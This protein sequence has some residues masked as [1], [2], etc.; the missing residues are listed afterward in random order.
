LRRLERARFLVERARRNVTATPVDFKQKCESE[1][2]QLLTD[3]NEVD[4]EIRAAEN[5][6]AQNLV[7]LAR[8]AHGEAERICGRATNSLPALAAFRMM[9]RMGHQFLLQAESL[10]EDGSAA[11]ISRNVV[12]RRLQELEATIVEVRSNVHGDQTGFAQILIM[13]ATSLRERAQAAYQRGY[14]VV[15]TETSGMA[16]DLLRE[17]LKLSK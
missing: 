8:T 6:E 13:Q 14:F 2:Q 16:L 11:N 4:E 7:E 15:A 10:S 1:L 5:P 12:Q 17:A 9:L 3:L